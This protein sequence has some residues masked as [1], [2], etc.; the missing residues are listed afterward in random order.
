[1]RHMWWWLGCRPAS[2]TV[3]G[4]LLSQGNTI[5]LCPGGVRECLYM[6]P[7]TEVAYLRK[8]HGFVKLALEHGAPL[9]P[10][11]AF[12]QSGMFSYCRPFLDFPRNV[13]SLRV[14]GKV[15]RRIGF[16]P[17]MVWGV[18]GTP[19]PHRVPLTIVVGRPI[20]M[21]PLPK[22]TTVAPP[23]LVEEYL[24]KFINELEALFETHKVDAGGLLPEERLTVY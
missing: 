6:A 15:A 7:G 3:A 9:V 4:N 18:W 22:G 14:F 16:A 13:V 8:R 17:M 1:M 23:A 11:F 2:R 24:G 12:G 21:P 19:M 5:A 10:V 20:E